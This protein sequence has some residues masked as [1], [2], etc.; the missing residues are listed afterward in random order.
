MT[1]R[2]APVWSESLNLLSVFPTAEV[3]TQTSAFKPLEK[4]AQIETGPQM[5]EFPESMKQSLSSEANRSSA[6]QE[7]PRILW[8][9]I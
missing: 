7:I 1:T 5:A 9:P 4:V 8:N 6:G 3:S 2:Y